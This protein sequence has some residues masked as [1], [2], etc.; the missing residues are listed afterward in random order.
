MGNFQLVLM[1]MLLDT[2]P[3]KHRILFHEVRC[4]SWLCVVKGCGLTRSK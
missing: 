3:L 1:D 2:F 4:A